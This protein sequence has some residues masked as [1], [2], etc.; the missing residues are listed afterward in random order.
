M[1]ELQ[2]NEC[3]R[4]FVFRGTK[5]Y[6][7]QAIQDML[8]IIYIHDREFQWLIQ[9]NSILTFNYRN[10]ARPAG[11]SQAAMRFI[12]PV[13]E[14]ELHLNSIIDSLQQDPWTVDPDKRPQRATG[15]ALQVAISLMESAFPNTGARIMLFAGGPCTVG[16]VYSLFMLGNSSKCGIERNDSFS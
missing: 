16:P 2:F 15:V 3:Q 11:V 4:S 10:V 8:V 5:E 13:T 6:T 9:N 12:Q 1:H 7:P 14:C